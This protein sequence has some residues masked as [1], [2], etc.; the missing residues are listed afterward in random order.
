VT[1]L[2]LGVSMAAVYVALVYRLWRRSP[3][4]VGILLLVIFTATW[5]M[6][7]ALFLDF[8]GS[9][10]SWELHADITATGGW[11]AGASLLVYVIGYLAYGS[12][13]SA[14]RLEQWR[15]TQ[16]AHRGH[17]TR[18]NGISIV[19]VIGGLLAVAVVA[20]YGE[21]F[22][23]GIG[24][25]PILSGMPRWQ[26]AREVAGPVFRLFG[27]VLSPLS[28]AVGFAVY[29]AASAGD[30]RTARG[31][32]GLFVLILVYLVL[33]GN[34]FTTPFYQV[35]F[36]LM[37]ASVLLLGEGGRLAISFRRL[38][39]V[40]AAATPVV[41]LLTAATYKV[42]MVDRGYTP[43]YLLAFLRQRVLIAPS[44]LSAGAFERVVLLGDWSPLEAVRLAVLDPVMPGNPS[45]GFL[46]FRE[47]GPVVR[48]L[49]VGFTDAFPGIVFELFGIAG[50]LPITVLT[51]LA[52]AKTLERLTTY[53][54]ERRF[55]HA[56]FWMV[57]AQALLMYHS[58]G[59]LIFLTSS[60]FLAKV[61]ITWM[62]MTIASGK[63]GHSLQVPPLE[64]GSEKHWNG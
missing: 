4:L 6:L 29:S 55:F 14:S 13:F 34:K 36:F 54:I 45:V 18:I 28:W 47:L 50:T 51:A 62:A 16:A 40:L 41:L 58:Q 63:L 17:V 7:S 35:C 3:M 43:Q 56:L 27:T 1:D 20:L 31:L 11:F 53:T 12:A 46:M 61:A 30:L 15:A 48:S 25:L 57:L 5:R 39:T 24:R 9:K 37:P 59:Q 26:Y 52:L 44:Q 32:S 64:V 60:R 22:L 33:I 42:F 8:G 38:R 10:Y 2:I 23:M 19:L 21:L 49:E